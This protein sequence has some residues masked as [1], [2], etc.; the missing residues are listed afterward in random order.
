MK[1]FKR[2]I[3][4]LVYAFLYAPLIIMV[5][6][7]FNS[8]RSTMVFEGFSLKWYE[9]LFSNN[10]LMECLQNSLILAVASSVIATILGTLAAVG[11]YK[12]KNKY[13]SGAIMS[14]NNIP[15]M[16]PDIV[17]G[18]SL[19][20]L[21]V[22]VGTFLGLTEKT[23]FW[24]LLIAHITFN[25]P[26]VLLNVLPK[27]KQTD[28]NLVEA[29]MDLG[30]TPNQAFFKVVM[31]QI[32]PG[33]M[34]GLLMAFTL[35][36]D[37]FVI[38]YYTSGTDFRTLPLYVYDIVKKPVKPNIY[39]LYSIIFILILVVLIVNNFVLNAPSKKESSGRVKKIVSGAL[40]VIILVVGIFVFKGCENDQ[41]VDGLQ[42]E[43][44]KEFEGTTLNVYNW[45]EY[46]S[47]GTDES[48][49]VITAFEQLT[50]IDVN[51]ITYESNEVMY[52][53]LKSGADSYDVVI[54]S[55][56]MIQRLKNEGM[57]KKL[58]FS[59]ISN[60]KNIDVRYKN[61]YFD[62]NNEY[63][64]P[65]S[66]GMVGLIYNTTMVKEKPTSWNVMWDERYTGDILTFNNSRD[67][68]AIAQKVLGQSFNTENKA[69]WDAAADLLK[70]QT[71]VLQGR[72]MD[73]V[74]EKMEGGNAAMAPYYVGDF[75]IMREEN[76][77]LDFVFPEEGVNVFVDSMC[78]PS[79]A[80]NYDAA[81]MFINFML[82][83]E[84]ALA[85]AEYIG[86]ASPNVEVVN[87]P[88]YCYKDDEYLYP[89]EEDMPE[90]E[91]F[92]DLPP[93]TRNYYEK[94]WVEI[95]SK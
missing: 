38:S 74:F 36:F 85:N 1:V 61:L 31:P 92:Y 76:E 12:L 23:N 16:N 83:P 41:S 87:H 5:F 59:Q 42:A 11:V 13:V 84:V 17:T 3:T 6:F 8:G 81:M 15:M 80:K 71:P 91:Y 93:E 88:D 67:A 53:K 24:T 29:A 86:Y 4:F 25:I 28:K 75:L 64:V 78:V 68:F 18:V 49:D 30:C 46:I 66:V 14:V 56:Y 27:L 65:Y 43:Y 52:S 60:Y 79:C 94:L 19:M 21:F 47:D 73:Q 51:Y 90:V 20:L 22:F 9:T 32:N 69:D 58:D 39:A 34:S 57:L 82:E 40:A 72:V 26:Y 50:G 77:D 48:L 44:S 70:K 2:L 63:T 54:P 7:S 10:V 55:D 45:G 62:E 95:T 33:I 37:D 89:A 35:S